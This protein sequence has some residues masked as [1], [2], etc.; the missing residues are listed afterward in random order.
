M[1]RPDRFVIWLTVCGWELERQFANLVEAIEWPNWNADYPT[2][3]AWYEE[4]VR[5]LGETHTVHSM[6]E[7]FDI[8]QLD[9]DSTMRLHAVAPGLLARLA[10]E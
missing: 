7:G 6:P 1:A 5:T 10:S 8:D 2:L 3:H 9:F 4:Q